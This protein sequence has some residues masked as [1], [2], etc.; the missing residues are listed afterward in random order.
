MQACFL[1]IEQNHKQQLLCSMTLGAKA[2]YPAD[3]HNGSLPNLCSSADPELALHW[4]S[5]I[6]HNS[7]GRGGEGINRR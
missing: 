6:R 2:T 7:Q 5:Q 1:L 3:A 4:E